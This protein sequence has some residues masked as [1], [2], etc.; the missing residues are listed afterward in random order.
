MAKI[1]AETLIEK[2]KKTK[3]DYLSIIAALE[4]ATLDHDTR[5][6]VATIIQETQIHENI[7]LEEIQN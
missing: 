4:D 1:Q 5:D 6:Q 7:A 2:L 3:I